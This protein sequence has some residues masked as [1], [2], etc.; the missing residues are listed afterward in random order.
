MSAP[1]LSIVQQHVE[2]AAHLRCVRSG[3]LRAPHVRL[4]EIALLDE[5]LCAHLDGIAVAGAVGARLAREA[6]ERP[7]V[8]EVFVATVLAIESEDASHLDELLAVAE[9]RADACRGLTS[10]LGWVSPQALRG[11]VRDLLA[12]TGWRRAIGLQACERHAVDPGPLL[13]AALDAVDPRVRAAALR[14]TG[15]LGRPERRDRCAAMASDADPGC[16]HEAARAAVLLGDR[17]R[18]VDVLLAFASD[19]AGSLPRRVQA[20]DLVLAVVDRHAARRCLATLARESTLRRAVVRA[21]G[22]RGDPHDVPWL[23]GLLDDPAFARIA[24]EAVATISGCDP[25]ALAAPPRGPAAADHADDDEDDDDSVADEDADLPWPDGG[26]LNAWWQTHRTQFGPGQR[27]LVGAPLAPVHCLQ[28]LRSGRQ[29]QRIAAA[30]YRS[31]LVPGTPLFDV[32][33]PAWRQQRLLAAA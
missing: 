20:L 16:A 10:A 22:L 31:L 14:L 29:R 18:A 11:V 27:C 28:V 25:A 24:A 32:G 7:G 12:S 6:L 21:V 8:G 9:A 1:I 4:R 3:L 23:L 33:A 30:T 2:E 15:R 5:R 17:S 19:A 26:A 13:D